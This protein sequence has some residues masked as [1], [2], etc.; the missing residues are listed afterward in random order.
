MTPT[1]IPKPDEG[2]ITKAY[3]EEIPAEI[4]SRDLSRSPID[5]PA[6]ET[7]HAPSIAIPQAATRGGINRSLAIGVGAA[8]LAGGIG[9]TVLASNSGTDQIPP[10]PSATASATITPIIATSAPTSSD[11]TSDLLQNRPNASPQELMN[12]LS[13]TPSANERGNLLEV[14]RGR[15]A[16]P[17]E[18]YVQLHQLQTTVSKDP[19]KP[20]GN[21]VESRWV[22][23][24]KFQHGQHNAK[25]LTFCLAAPTEEKTKEL[26]LDFRIGGELGSIAV[27]LTANPDSPDIKAAKKLFERAEIIIAQD[28]EV[29]TNFCV[30]VNP[31]FTSSCIDPKKCTQAEIS[32]STLNISIKKD[33]NAFGRVEHR[34]R[35]CEK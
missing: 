33:T 16:K 14:V 9:I 35:Q 3:E 18:S 4:S 31:C 23:P 25:A 21:V 32:Q 24:K 15:L 13:K 30:Q 8:F 20:D 29:K 11:P 6:P 27:P 34:V 1:E 2:R 28:P 12:G 26:S 10:T 19:Q 17:Q 5:T 7:K 22:T